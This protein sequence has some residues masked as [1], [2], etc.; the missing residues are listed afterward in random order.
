MSAV[1][2]DGLEDEV[3]SMFAVGEQ[4]GG[5]VI[6]ARLGAGGFGEVFLAR[7]RSP[8]RLVA[9]KV[10]RPEFAQRFDREIDAMA[11]VEHPNVVPIYAHG[12]ERGL[13]Y[14][15]MRYVRGGS[16]AAFLDERP[17]ALEDVVELLAGV[18]EGLDHCHARGIVHRDLK[19]ANVLVDAERGCGLLTDFGIATAADLPTLT[20]PGAGPGTPAYM[21]PETFMGGPATAASDLWALGAIVYRAA[22]GVLPRGLNQ[23]FDGEVVRPSV[24]NERLGPE[25]D[26]V[27]LR[28]L[29]LD[30]ARRHPNARAFVSEL[31]D[32]LAR[33]RHGVR[34]TRPASSAGGREPTRRFAPRRVWSLAGAAL[35]L[36]PVAYGVSSFT[37]RGSP[38]AVRS[39]CHAAYADACLK[40]DSVDYDCKGGPGDGPDYV[41]GRVRVVGTDEF[42]L[43]RDGDG[44]GC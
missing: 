24:R 21:A 41:S 11:A 25:V 18:A 38:N 39:D 13:R 31:R 17:R 5:Y 35:L 43:D 10:V 9:L 3:P 22:A 14:F 2:R 37:E 44:I 30:P 20:A 27:I 16:L 7:E 28:S 23:P 19:P 15:A 33:P 12:R 4:V 1:A 32:A 34:F 6:E 40:A 26:R 8:K 36:V 42:R 29:S